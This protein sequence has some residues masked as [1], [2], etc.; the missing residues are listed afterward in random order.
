MKK[1]TLGLA[2]LL[3]LFASCDTTSYVRGT[4]EMWVGDWI[5]SASI[6]AAIIAEHTVYPYH[7]EPGSSALNDAGAHTV[8][9]LAGHYH[10]TSGELN[11]N[12]GD[13]SEALYQA[14]IDALVAYMTELGVEQGRVTIAD[15][16]P[17]G[18]G[19]SSARVVRVLER[20]AASG[21]PL[22]P[23]TSTN[24]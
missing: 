1:K 21:G 13:A 24:N 19:I 3:P 8:E 14:R 4:N 15:S 11:V 16:A 12:R 20:D 5:R 23:M 10:D 2:L 6:E 22:L 18:D 9:V 17:G 7:F